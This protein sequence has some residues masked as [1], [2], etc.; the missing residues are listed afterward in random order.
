MPANISTRGSAES[1]LGLMVIATLALT[2]RR[3]Y[4]TAAIMLGLAVHFKIYP[5]IY[6]ASILASMPPAPSSTGPSPLL[7]R[8]AAQFTR[9]RVRFTLVSLATFVIL[10]IGMY[11][12]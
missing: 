2:M 4:D 1:V 11:S 5:F 3:R 12:M 9:Q 10:N 7:T 8:I 6:G